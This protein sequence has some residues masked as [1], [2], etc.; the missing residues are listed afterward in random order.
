MRTPAAGSDKHGYRKQ[1]HVRFTPKSGHLRCTYLCPLWAKS[2]LVQR[3]KD[4]RYSITSLARSGNAG[5]IFNPI[6]LAGLQVDY[7]LVLGQRL[8][9][10]FA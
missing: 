9:R 6:T 1:S 3:S 5:G 2:G 8:N 7:Q 10:Q 4:K